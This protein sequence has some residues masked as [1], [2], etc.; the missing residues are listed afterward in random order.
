MGEM[1]GGA[2][3]SSASEKSDE[4]SDNDSGSASSD[5]SSSSS[6][7]AGSKVPVSKKP[8]RGTTASSRKRASSPSEPEWRQNPELYGIRTSGRNRRQVEK[9]ASENTGESDHSPQ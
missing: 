9:Y 2:A 7:G 5:S 1:K 6:L 8:G 3:I 4:E